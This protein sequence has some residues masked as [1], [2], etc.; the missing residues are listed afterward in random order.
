MKKAGIITHYDVHNHGA[1]LQLYALAQ[2]LKEFGYDAKALQFQKNYDFM[3]CSEAKKKYNISIHSVPTYIKYVLANGISR[4]LYNIKKRRILAQFREKQDLVGEYYSEAKSLDLVVIGSDEIFSIEAGP[5]PWYYGIGVP[6]KNQIS[7]A[8]S[9]GPTTFSMIKEH[10][11]ESL[12]EAGLKHLKH[13]AVRD[14][15]SVQIVWSFVGEKPTVVCDPVL[16]YC[17]NNQICKDEIEIFRQH[18][19]EKY[20]VVYSYDSNM[21]DESTI[22]AIKTFAKKR[23]LKTISVGYFHKWCDKCIN[24]DP[25]DVFKW[26]ACAEMVFTD[27]FHGAVL[28]IVTGSQFVSRIRGNSNKLA[29]LLDQYGLKDRLVSDFDNMSEVTEKTINYAIVNDTITRIR[30]ESFKYLTNAICN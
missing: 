17:F 21:N 24:L 25:L 12:V 6:C 10:N 3:G 5:N 29:F 14:E 2:I 4:T 22:S 28:S 9:F 7:Y 15:N 16:L 19:T 18:Q 20:C 11:M 8:A 13:I 30:S 26:F 1:H 27:T 23:K